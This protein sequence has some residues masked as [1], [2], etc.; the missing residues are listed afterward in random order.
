MET[1][2]LTSN[3]AIKAYDS[4]GHVGQEILIR[5][6]YAYSIINSTDTKRTYTGYADVFTDDQHEEVRL[7]FSLNPGET[8]TLNNQTV[9][10][11]YKAK[12]PGIFPIVARIKIVNESSSFEA[13][14]EATLT[15]TM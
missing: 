7:T 6:I 1:E 5:A 4:K 13:S 10:F 3:V 8:R 12:R 9:F 14:S 2:T 15:V 11:R